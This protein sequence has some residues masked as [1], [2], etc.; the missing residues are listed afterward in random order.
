M[1]TTDMTGT[2]STPPFLPGESTAWERSLEEVYGR[3]N[4][5]MH[6]LLMWVRYELDPDTPVYNHVT[7]TTLHEAIGTS[8]GLGTSVVE[9]C[10]NR[11]PPVATDAMEPGERNGA[12][13]IEERNT[14]SFCKNVLVTCPFPE[15]ACTGG[16]EIE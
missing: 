9:G 4:L 1:A 16:S 2:V 10:S 15:S 12:Q 14:Q 6:E 3:S 7:T 8:E 13:Y 11:K 5:T